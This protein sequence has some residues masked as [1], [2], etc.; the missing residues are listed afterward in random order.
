[1]NHPE[2]TAFF[3]RRISFI[4]VI[5]VFLL[6][7]KAVG[8]DTKMP[9]STFKGGSYEQTF[10]TARIGLTQSVMI[11]PKGEFHLVIN[12]RFSDVSS[13]IDRF[14]GLDYAQTRIG[15]DYGIT[16]WLSGTFGMNLSAHLYELALKAAILKQKENEIP[17]SLS[18]YTSAL[19]ATY[20]GGPIDTIGQYTFGGK[21]SFVNQLNIARNQGILSFQVS[22]LWLH[23][24]DYKLTPGGPLDIF[25]VAL[26]GRV[27][28]TEML[29]IIGEYVPVATNESFIPANPFTIGLDINTGKHQFQLIFS[30]NQ[31]TNEYSML[32][33]PDSGH[34]Y[35]GFNLTRVFNAASE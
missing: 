31:G 9:E 33:Y 34:L 17:V 12:H 14:F 28:L 4:L 19:E 2:Q 11:A 27:R 8:Q 3:S 23:V 18:W 30:N 26:S 6:P 35:F 10:S 1:M 5:L 7:G 13:G 20:P 22:P 29:G 32:T 24:N 25:A 21:L 16:K 15:L